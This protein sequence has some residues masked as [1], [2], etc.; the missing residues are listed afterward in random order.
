MTSD[1][2]PALPAV[3]SAGGAGPSQGPEDQE[4]ADKLEDELRNLD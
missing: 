1:R 3:A 4:L 2:R